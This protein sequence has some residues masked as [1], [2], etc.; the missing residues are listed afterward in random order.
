VSKADFVLR[1]CEHAD[2]LDVGCIDHSAETAIAG[3]SK[4]LH[5]RIRDAAAQV[6]G[7]DVLEDDA[8]RLNAL[9][10]DI[11]VGSAESFSLG[12]TFEVIVAA[13]VLEHLSNIGTFLDTARSHMTSASRLVL[14]TPNPF[15]IGQVAHVI[16]RNEVAVNAEHTV[17]L[18]PSVML[19]LLTRHRFA[20]TEFAWLAEDG[21]A[22]S[23]RSRAVDRVAAPLVA[24]RPFLRRNYGVVAMAT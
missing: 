6:V 17:W 4:W 3:G 21:R 20:A 13:D 2:V 23:M 18:D 24:R 5:H 19:E 12:R 1:Q 10:Y 9:G 22:A 11:V 16:L 8:A 7:L 15:S 14:T